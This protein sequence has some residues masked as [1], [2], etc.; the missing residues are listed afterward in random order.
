MRKKKN[1]GLPPGS[2]IY[3]G[4]LTGDPVQV[5]YIE[6]NLETFREDDNT[7][8]KGVILHASNP[9]ITQWYDVRGLHEENLIQSISERFQMHPIAIEDA[10]DV[11]QRPTFT[12]YTNGLFFSL[13][14]LRFDAEKSEVK[15]ESLAIYFG[16]GFVLS[17]QEL[18]DDTFSEVR[19]RITFDRGR[20]RGKRA[21]YLA[22]A[23]IDYTVDQ[24]YHVIDQ[25]ES[26]V[27][28]LEETISLDPDL[29]NKN[30][31]YNLKKQ[32]LKIRKSVSPIRE[33]INL[34]SRSESKLIDKSTINYIRDVYDH[35]IHIVDNIDSLRDILS[36][37]YDLYLSELSM[38]MNRTMQ[39]LTI[40][41]SIF[42][43]ISFLAGLYG[44]N[45]EYI[46]ELGYKYGYFILLTAMVLIAIVMLF[47]FKKKNWL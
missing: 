28:D 18:V 36:G 23:L 44:M 10:V 7:D 25:L 26:K 33:A 12:E 43:P 17:F 1:I 20:I 34:F 14:V 30:E 22:Y 15:K 3:T 38:K 46:P 4:K 6:Y 2:I 39:F 32:I 16:D 24:Y 40:I 47:I 29:V 9:T 37:L 35:T 31:I 5:N 8:G 45:F 13:K 41:T 21:D 27:E 11:F 42:V 19:K